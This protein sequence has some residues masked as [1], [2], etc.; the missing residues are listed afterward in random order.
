MCK[1]TPIKPC[2]RKGAA[3]L[4]Q[5]LLRFQRS[6]SR[7]LGASECIFTNKPDLELT[8][9]GWGGYLQEGQE[10]QRDNGGDEG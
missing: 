2:K 6:N 8:A 5:L 7:N 3:E 10:H 1:F 9:G 4:L